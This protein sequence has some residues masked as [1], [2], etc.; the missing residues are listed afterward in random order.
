MTRLPER[1]LSGYRNFINNHFSYKTEH[2]QQL[3]IEGQKP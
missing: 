3:A 1:L 2:Y